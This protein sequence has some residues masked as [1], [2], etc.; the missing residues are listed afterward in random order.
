MPLDWSPLVEFVR[1]H[2]RFLLMTHV[3]PDGDALGSE[4]ALAGA[5]RAL[6]K[7]ARTA[8]A[9]RLPPRYDF[10]SPDGRIERFLPPGDNFRDVGAVLVV[11]T[12]TWSQLGEFGP[13]LRTLDVPRLVIDHHRTQDDLG[14]ARLVD[15]SAEACCRLITEAIDALGVPMS[16]EIATNL[17]I[18]LAMDT[19]W[20]HHAGTRPETFALADRLTRAGADPH[21]L[22]DLL[23]E[24]NSLG[25][26]QMLGRVLGRLKPY[27]GGRLIVTEVHLADYDATGAVPGD[28]EDMVNYTRSI[29]GCD[30]GVILIEQREG[31]VKVSWRS[32]EGGV[33]VSKLAERFGGGGH[34]L[35]AGAT[36]PGPM[37]AAHEAVV[38]ATL[39]A[40]G[41]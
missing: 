35:A 11:D 32:R 19:G 15:T 21:V 5:L 20:F 25:R 30:V 37:A 14:G 7:H 16:A 33:D 10:M 41:Q 24:R 2:D 17:F 23:Y 34:R 36:V 4:L 18:G 28:T 1:S 3:R 9:S 13:F 38:Q 8:I 40:L 39:A 6:G 26:L 12:G 22:Y 31:G 29:D 27:A